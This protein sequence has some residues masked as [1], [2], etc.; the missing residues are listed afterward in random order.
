MRK[1]AA[2]NHPQQAKVGAG[3]PQAT[4]PVLAV[5]RLVLGDFRCYRRLV[6]EAEPQPQVLSGPNGAGKTNLLEA[7]SFLSPG[8][9]LRQARLGEVTRR[10][11]AGGWTVAASVGDGADRIEIGTGLA[12]AA[13]GA[14]E[15]RVVKLDGEPARGPAALSAQVNVV[16]L[17]PRMDRLFVERPRERRR[18]LDRLVFGFDAD[19]ARRVAAY[20]HAMRERTRLMR[21]G[22]ADAAWI[23][24]LER[25][26]AEHGVAVAAA[27]RDAVAWL[28]QGLASGAGPFPGAEVS[29]SGTLEGWLDEMPALEV[30]ER[31][32][33]R[34]AEARARDAAAG[35]A[36]EGPHRSDLEVRHADHGIPAAQCSTGEQKALLIA[37]VL[38]NARLQ[39]AQR[40][41]APLLLLDE[42]A[43]HLDQARRQALFEALRA[44]R[45]QAWLT[46]TDR[47]LFEGLEGWAQYSAVSDG[48][49]TAILDA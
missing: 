2:L 23:A 37:I 42:V 8:R 7:L 16:W 32:A 4:L 36:G 1:G 19:H 39:A 13:A 38:A 17:T 30:E 35:S 41:R 6:L 25:G 44:T 12:P 34:L 9:G 45:A 31:F 11:A 40:G 5:R 21:E 10:G 3:R 28:R 43:A 48:R 47:A 29:V 46:G 14:A 33:A 18:F 27:R 49:V 22:G 26:M 24:A 15:R 20:E